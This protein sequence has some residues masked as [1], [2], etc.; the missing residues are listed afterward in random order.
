MDCICLCSEVEI[1]WFFYFYIETDLHAFISYQ[2]IKTHIWQHITNQNLCD[3][4]TVF[5]Y[6][7]GKG[8]FCLI[9]W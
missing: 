8:D 4:I 3:V 2:P 7:H 5:P 9:G 6:S 1:C